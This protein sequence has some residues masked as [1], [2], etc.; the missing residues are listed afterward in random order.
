MLRAASLLQRSLGF[1]SRTKRVT[2]L[3]SSV[4][5]LTPSAPVP[6]PVPVP[7]SVPVSA[8]WSV[9]MAGT[10][11]TVPLP[12]APVVLEDTIADPTLLCGATHASPFQSAVF[13]VHV[14]DT[15]DACQ[16]ACQSVCASTRVA[17]DTE[18][19]TVCCCCCC[20]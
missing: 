14:V 1:I 5:A 4:C 2:W 15:L 17:V 8:S 13:T 6:A 10:R 11:T 19:V 20:C 12:H 9:S 7:V 16:E 18:F 3:H